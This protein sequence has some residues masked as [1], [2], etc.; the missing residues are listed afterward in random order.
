MIYRAEDM[1]KDW[2]SEV[3][4]ILEYHHDTL[5]FSNWGDEPK[6]SNCPLDD[7]TEF[8]RILGVSP[9]RVGTACSSNFNHPRH[10]FDPRIG[11]VQLEIET[12]LAGRLSYHSKVGVGRATQVAVVGSVCRDIDSGK[13]V[14]LHVLKIREHVIVG[15]VSIPQ[16]VAQ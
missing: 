5:F 15:N 12:Q 7:V 10:V 4:V 13:T 2:A 9:K 14:I 8:A 3:F 11:C 1:S 6:I 16:V